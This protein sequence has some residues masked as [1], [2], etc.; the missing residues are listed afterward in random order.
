MALAVADDL[1]GEVEA[2][3]QTRGIYH[4]QYVR[5]FRVFQ[6]ALEMVYRDPLFRGNRLQGIGAGKVDQLHIGHG[7]HAADAHIHRDTGKVRHLVVQPG[8]LVEQQALA[9]VGAA[10]QD[11]FTHCHPAA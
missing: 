1:Q 7:P 8:E 3:L 6:G 10:D 11:Y 4:T 9:R 2:L 5:H